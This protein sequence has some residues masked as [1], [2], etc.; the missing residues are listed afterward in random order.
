MKYFYKKQFI[1]R[2]VRTFAA[3]F[4]VYNEIEFCN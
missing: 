1:T 2:N 4:I 3:S